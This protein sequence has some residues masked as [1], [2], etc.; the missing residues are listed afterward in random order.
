MRTLYFD[1]FNGAS[2]DMILGALIDAG[3]PL[4]AVRAA[5]GSL[6]IDGYQVAADRVLRAGVSATKFRVLDAAPTAVALALAPPR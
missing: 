3:V 5:L 1:C 2:G 4:D 6:A